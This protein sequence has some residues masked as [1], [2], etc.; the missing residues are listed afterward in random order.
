MAIITN[1]DPQ[2]ELIDST[3]GIYLVDAGA[4]TGKTYSIVK[5]YSN[6]ID[7]NIKPEDILLVTFT[8]NAA[9]QMKQK[10]IKSMSE[11][12]EVLQLLEAPV[13]TFHSFCS[14]IVKKYGASSPSYLGLK[15]YLPANYGI[16]EDSDLESELFRKF[17][18]SFADKYRNQYKD[19]FFILEKESDNIL[20]IIKK[21]CSLGIFPEDITWNDDALS[22]LS[23][24]YESYT[25]KLFCYVVM[26][27]MLDCMTM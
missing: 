23:G 17:Y 9:K 15:N 2:Q 19:I 10:I 14:Q 24:D 4:G 16:I 5:R 27:N 12:I 18:L 20:K 11:R 3:E 13:M 25:K 7:K 21:L 22:V 26:I 6:I 8:V 1:I